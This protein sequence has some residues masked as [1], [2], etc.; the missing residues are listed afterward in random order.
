MDD[1]GGGGGECGAFGGL[2]GKGSRNTQ[3]T[4]STTNPGRHSGKPATDCLS[5]ARHYFTLIRV[6]NSIKGAG[7][8]SIVL[9]NINL[10]C[11]D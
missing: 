7:Y 2:S 3:C 11:A 4:L 8:S 9:F 6:M 1:D 5:Y 10:T